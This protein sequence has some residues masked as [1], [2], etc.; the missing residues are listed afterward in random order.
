MQAAIHS[1]AQLIAA[2]QPRRLLSSKNISLVDTFVSPLHIFHAASSVSARWEERALIVKL[3]RGRPSAHFIH[4]AR[5]GSH[6]LATAPP[7][8]RVF[9]WRQLPHD[10]VYDGRVVHSAIPN[11]RATPNQCGN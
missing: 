8:A 1:A 2:A 7:I 11:Q 4:L 5:S 9:E 10:Q 3:D 6:W